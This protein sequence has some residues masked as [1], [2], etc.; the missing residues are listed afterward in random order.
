MRAGVWK[1][2]LTS[3]STLVFP[4][5]SPFL[6]RFFFVEVEFLAVGFAVSVVNAFVHR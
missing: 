1:Q 5:T 2:L 4:N 3:N 6:D